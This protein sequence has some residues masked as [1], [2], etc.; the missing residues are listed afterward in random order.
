[1]YPDIEIAYDLCETRIRQFMEDDE[2]LKAQHEQEEE[3]L[4]E[5]VAELDD[6]FTDLTIFR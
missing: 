1:M 6:E 2:I 4:K 5:Q 3:Q